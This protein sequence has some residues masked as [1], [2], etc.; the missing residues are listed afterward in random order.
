M[1][2]YLGIVKK[3]TKSAIGV[4]IKVLTRFSNSK[5]LL[6]QWMKLYPKSKNI[7]LKNTAELELFFKDFEDCSPLT[8]E[9][10]CIEEKDKDEDG[11]YHCP[12]CYAYVYKYEH[13]CCECGIKIK[14]INS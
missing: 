13:R 2:K 1:E 9:E 14:F 8:E 3:E 12:E 6:M 5:E 11:L 4:N 10:Y 7:L